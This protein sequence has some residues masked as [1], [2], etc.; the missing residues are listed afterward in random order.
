MDSRHPAN[1]P[2]QDD[3]AALQS[4]V[5]ALEKENASLLGENQHLRKLLTDAGIAITS[6][7]TPKDP[8]QGARPPRPAD[9]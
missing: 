7:P 3:L 8:N 5:I 9:L 4:R 6:A 2:V 1:A